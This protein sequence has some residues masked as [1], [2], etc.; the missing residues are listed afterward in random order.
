MIRYCEIRPP[1]RLRPFINTFWVL[2]HDGQDAAPQRVVPDGHS[3]LILNWGQP[4]E[5]F[6]AGQWHGQPRCFLAGQIDGPL[7]LR[8]NGPARMLGIGFHPHGAARVFAHPMHELSGRF[9]PVDDLSPA[10]ARK[11]NHAMESRDPIAAVEAALVSAEN[12]S[13]GG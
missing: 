3:E 6:R 5:S 1:D 2:E 11:L 12:T 13:R 4:F 7:L 9:T 8:P 10:L